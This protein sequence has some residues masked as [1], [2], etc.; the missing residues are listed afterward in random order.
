MALTFI[1]FY[2]FRG[3]YMLVVFYS[4]LVNSLDVYECLYDMSFGLSIIFGI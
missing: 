3:E 2:L 4:Y 1:V